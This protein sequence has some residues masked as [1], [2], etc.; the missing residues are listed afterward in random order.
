MVYYAL[1][2]LVPLLLLLLSGLGLV[3]RYSELA[4]A[5]GQ[6]VLNTVEQQVGADL[7]AARRRC[8]RSRGTS[9]RR[10]SSSMACSSAETSTRTARSADCWWSWSG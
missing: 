2:S 6:Q 1:I 7:S 9:R 5:A 3:L 8:A 4:N 10:R